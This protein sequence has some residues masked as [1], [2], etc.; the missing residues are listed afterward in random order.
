MFKPKA[1][2]ERSGAVKS[3]PGPGLRE[4]M[5]Q[6]L[7][8]LVEFRLATDQRGSNLYDGVAAVVGAAIEAV[9]SG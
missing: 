7:L 4:N 5:P 8:H 3:E 6:D 2:I 1:V 9:T